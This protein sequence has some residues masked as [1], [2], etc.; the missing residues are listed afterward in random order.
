M[1]AGEIIYF[2]REL[3]NDKAPNII[4]DL[5]QAL[6]EEAKSSSALLK[7]HQLATLLK[8][9][10]NFSSHGGRIDYHAFVTTIRNVVAALNEVL[11]ITSKI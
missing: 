4:K 7:F 11:E 2:C 9:K 8:D 10:R 3:L 1:N 5:R 6:P